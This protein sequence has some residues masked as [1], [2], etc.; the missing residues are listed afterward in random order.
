MFVMH[1]QANDKEGF[2]ARFISVEG[3]LKE[4]ISKQLSAEKRLDTKIAAHDSKVNQMILHVDSR[5]KQ[6]ETLLREQV[7]SA[8]SRLRA[9]ARDV[10]QQMG[11]VRCLIASRMPKLTFYRSSTKS[12][13]L[14]LYS[15]GIWPLLNTSYLKIP[16]ICPAICRVDAFEY[17]RPH[18]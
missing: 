1:V 7:E 11:Q 10:E 8:M 3:T 15:F 14:W 2:L 6:S 12:E 9:Y 13:S 17:R 4:S 16:Y 18:D 5:M